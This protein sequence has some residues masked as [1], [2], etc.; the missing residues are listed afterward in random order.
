MKMRMRMRK[1]RRMKRRM[2]M[3]R[4]RMNR[5]SRRSKDTGM[6][7]QVLNGEIQGPPSEL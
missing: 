7:R 6:G 2:R 1:R 5:P 4:I 3:K